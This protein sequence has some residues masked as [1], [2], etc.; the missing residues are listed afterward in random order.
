MFKKKKCLIQVLFIALINIFQV[1]VVIKIKNPNKIYSL[2]LAH[3]ILILITVEMNDGKRKYGFHPNTTFEIS[4]IE[5]LE[6]WKTLEYKQ[7]YVY[8]FFKKL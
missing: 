3:G 8:F 7:N 5:N 6:N 1:G 2:I 4:D